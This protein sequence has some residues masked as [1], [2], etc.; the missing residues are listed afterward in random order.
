VIRLESRGEDFTGLGAELATEVR[1]EMIRDTREAQGLIFRTVRGLLSRRGTGREYRSLRG[2]GASR[3]SGGRLRDV[4]G[5]FVSPRR[6]AS[7]EGEPPAP[8][9][10]SY[11]DSIAEAPLEI[12]TDSVAADVYTN[13]PR[14]PWFEYGTRNMGPRPHWRPA[15]EEAEPEVDRILRG[16]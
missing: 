7:R 11:R 10:F 13:D 5:R 16:G 12:T 4:A 15:M 6:R 14:G 8:D 1:P 3:D 2:R 9:T